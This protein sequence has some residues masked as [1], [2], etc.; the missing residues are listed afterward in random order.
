MKEKMELLAISVMY[1]EKGVEGVIEST[2]HDKKTARNMCK[3]NNENFKE[4]D[5]NVT[6]E[7]THI[8]TLT[9]ML[10]L[11]KLIR[12]AEDLEEVLTRIEKH[13][14]N[15]REIAKEEGVL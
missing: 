15:I 12:N 10:S 6:Y 14:K 13:C 7:Y 9:K 4:Y 3:I 1:E 11:K 2:I 5:F 8:E